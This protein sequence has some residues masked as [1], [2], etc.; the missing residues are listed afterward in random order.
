MVT[1]YHLKSITFRDTFSTSLVYFW[2]SIHSKKISNM[3][4]NVVAVCTHHLSHNWD[5]DM[6]VSAH[7]GT[8]VKV[9]VV[10]LW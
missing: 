2:K 7:V 8:D 10:D 4:D 3:A 9:W 6:Y 1:A 5:L